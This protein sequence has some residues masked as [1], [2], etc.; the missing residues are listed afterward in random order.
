MGLYYA[1]MC[2]AHK[3]A[4]IIDKSGRRSFEGE[5]I[6]PY[7]RRFRPDMMPEEIGSPD[8]QSAY[9]RLVFLVRAFAAR[10]PECE[11]SIAHDQSSSTWP[12]GEESPSGRWG[13]TGAVI[14]RPRDQTQ[15]S[16]W[17]LFSIEQDEEWVRR[18]FAKRPDIAEREIAQ[19]KTDLAAVLGRS[20]AT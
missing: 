11:L 18:W 13:P 9:E 6:G 12:W 7:T 2:A 8:A 14:A 19:G 10:H 15:P 16:G 20:R 1:V 4:L 17:T 3:E 5:E